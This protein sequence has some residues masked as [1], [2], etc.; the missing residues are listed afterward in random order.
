MI[1]VNFGI[2]DGESEYKEWSYYETFSKADYDKGKIKGL[3]MTA[4][5]D[6]TEQQLLQIKEQIDLLA[7]QALAIQDRIQ[8]SEK[9]YQAQYNFK[10]VIGKIYHLYEREDQNPSPSLIL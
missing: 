10:P 7:K 4:M 5:Y 6:Q 1:L 9:I 2:Q 3:A 8:I